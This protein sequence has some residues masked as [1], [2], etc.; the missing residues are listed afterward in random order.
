MLYGYIFYDSKPITAKEI[1]YSSQLQCMDEDY[2][3]MFKQIAIAEYNPNDTDNKYIISKCNEYTYKLN[4]IKQD[5][6][7]LLGE[8]KYS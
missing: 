7:W 8:E 2:K 1:L 4:T 5:G 6:T 3:N